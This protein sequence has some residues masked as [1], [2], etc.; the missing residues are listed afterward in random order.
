[1]S[2]YSSTQNW[3]K[4][5]IHQPL[6][7]K[8]VT[9]LSSIS[10]LAGANVAGAEMKPF[11]TVPSASAPSFQSRVLPVVAPLPQLAIS[12]PAAIN[13]QNS[14]SQLVS[15]LCS[16]VR[17]Q[18]RAI[19]NTRQLTAPTQ[20]TPTVSPLPVVGRQPLP[21]R[22][23]ARPPVESPIPDAVAIY[24]APPQSNVIPTRVVESLSRIPTV[25]KPVIPRLAPIPKVVARVIAPKTVIANYAVASNFIYPLANPAP[26][27]SQ[28][29]WR[30]H[31]ISGN[32][33]F[34]AGIDLGAPAGAP[35]VAAATGRV[36]VANWHGGYGKAVVIEHD[37]QLQTLYGHMSEIL[38]QEGQEVKQGEVLGLVGS[39]GN[40]TGPHLHF[41]T[42]APTNDGWI[43]ID[44]SQELQ[45]ALNNLRQSIQSYQQEKT[46]N[47]L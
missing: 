19:V 1:M 46:P 43:A 27:T 23:Q 4:F 33:R 38:V 8:V 6:L 13:C 26:M 39:T 22:I 44:P 10:L 28:F 17:P 5:L 20:I 3:W 14:T 30:V 41:E 35:I 11:T 16:Q 36:V 32:R 37:G 42:H 47:R 15:R 40:S 29:G 45:Y 9:W 25:S 24:I 21:A 2:E 12:K 7:L 31:P 34:H 18:N